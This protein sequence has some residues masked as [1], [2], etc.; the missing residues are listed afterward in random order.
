MF[1][2][3]MTGLFIT[4]SGNRRNQF[5]VTSNTPP[6]PPLTPPL[7]PIIRP[8]HLSSDPATY[9]PTE[10]CAAAPSPPSLVTTT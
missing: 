3:R 10:S 8:R 5:F 4:G 9:H 1:P 6:L 2:F 7:P